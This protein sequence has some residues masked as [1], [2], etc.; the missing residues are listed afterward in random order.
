MYNLHGMQDDV[1]IVLN[2]I[3]NFEGLSACI[4]DQDI[5][6]SCAAYTSHPNAMREPLI[7]IDVNCKGVINILEAARRFN[8]DLNIVHVGTST[9]IGRMLFEPI[10]ETHPEFPV[11]IYS[12]NKSA[13]EKYV[14][15]YG[16]AY[17]MRTCVVRFPNAFGPRSNIKRPDFGFIN[18]FV[19]QAL[20]DRELTVFGSGRQ[21]RNIVHVYDCVSA[22]VG[23]AE[24]ERAGGK[25][26][27]AVSDKHY[28]VAELA[29]AVAEVIGG[30][31][32]FVDWP[33]DRQAIEVGDAVISNALITETLNWSPEYDLR[34]G[35]IQTA[36]YF[37]PCLKEY[38]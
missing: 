2:D 21:K 17:G 4:R 32:R 3:R 10:T 18:W 37:R 12:A 1:N 23:A 38:L 7:D 16:S 35:L 30:R 15:I 28:T 11:D 26:L 29:G 8:Q 34:R 27:F 20:Q 25:V 5:L 19:G 6:F 22:L 33:K 9:Q 13:S 14:L 36:E 31:V 24:C